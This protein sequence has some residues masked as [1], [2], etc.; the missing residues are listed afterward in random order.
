M[1]RAKWRASVDFPILGAPRSR[2][3][4]SGKISGTAQR[5]AGNSMRRRSFPLWARTFDEGAGAPTVFPS[6]KAP[7]SSAFFIAREN[8]S[9]AAVV[10]LAQTRSFQSPGTAGGTTR[11]PPTAS[12]ARVAW[13]TPGFA[14]V[15]SLASLSAAKTTRTPGRLPMIPRATGSKFPASMAATTQ[16]GPVEGKSSATLHAVA[17]PSAMT[18][19]SAFRSSST[20]PRGQKC[21][22]LAVQR[23]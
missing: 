2:L 1:A 8:S 11:A 4:P 14:A 12:A 5:G 10:P 19:V 9:R 23:G 21:P 22:V 7:A 13:S 20:P 6:T 18:T 17:T 3:S 15:P 16:K